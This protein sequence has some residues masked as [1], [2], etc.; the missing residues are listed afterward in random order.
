MEMGPAPQSTI[1]EESIEVLGLRTAVR[2]VGGPDA[3]AVV[4]LHGNPGSAR[5]WDGLLRAVGPFAHGVAF[6]L[7]GF[8]QAEKPVDWDYGAGA[9][10][11]FIHASLR[12]L[13]ITRA[14]LVMHDLG[15]VALLWAVANPQAFASAVLIDT[16]VP[17]GFRWHPLARLYRAPL[18]GELM[19]AAAPRSLFNGFMRFYNPQPRKL[20]QAFV[21]RLYADYDLGTRRAGL[22]FYRSSPPSGFERLAPILRELDVPALVLWGAHDVGIPVEQAERQRDSFPRAEVVVLPDSGHWPFIDDPESARRAVVPF[23]E[24]QLGGVARA[25]TRA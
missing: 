4:F 7:P 3:E 5:D 20:P 14:H 25:Q 12:R 9:Y 2:S 19:T 18:V 17:I 23:L 1:H 16:G 24:R 22:R 21:E 6:D 8:G 13:G 11:M 15:G 10:C